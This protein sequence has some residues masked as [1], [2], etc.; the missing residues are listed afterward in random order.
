MQ[1]KDFRCPDEGRRNDQDQILLGR[2]SAP[3]ALNPEILPNPEPRL[4]NRWS[5]EGRAS[6]VGFRVWGFRVSGFRGL[7]FRGVGV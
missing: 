6:W 7:G 5:M 3:P 2:I 4:R 1:P